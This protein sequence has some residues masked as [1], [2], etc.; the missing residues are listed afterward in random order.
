V[1]HQIRLLEADLGARLLNRSGRRISLT[2]AVV[3]GEGLTRI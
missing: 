2:V 1:S 3:T